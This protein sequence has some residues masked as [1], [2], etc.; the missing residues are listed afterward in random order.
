MEKVEKD[1][2]RI[3]KKLKRKWKKVE[4]ERKVQKKC[5]KNW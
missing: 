4:A 2:E 1:E 5:W 3:R